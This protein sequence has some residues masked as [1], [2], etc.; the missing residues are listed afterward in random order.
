VL[1]SYEDLTLKITGSSTN[2][3]EATLKYD[4]TFRRNIPSGTYKLHGILKDGKLDLKSNNTTDWIIH[5]KGHGTVDLLG[6]IN[7]SKY[8]GDFCGQPFD[9]TRKL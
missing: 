2:K 9:L 8:K 7:S 5:P 4:I 1:S 6:K 3:V